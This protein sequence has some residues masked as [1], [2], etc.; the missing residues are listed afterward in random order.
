MWSNR[1]RTATLDAISQFGRVCGK[2]RRVLSNI[3]FD[4]L[5]IPIELEIDWMVGTSNSM[6]SRVYVLCREVEVSVGSVKKTLPFF[7][8]EGLAQEA[9]L[10]RPWGRM[11]RAKHDNRDDRSL[12]TTI[13]DSDRNTA[14]FARTE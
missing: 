13:S 6:R 8:M 9:I 2:C 12:F 10:G 4:K 7:V 11:V 3:F 14:T 5:G 1:K